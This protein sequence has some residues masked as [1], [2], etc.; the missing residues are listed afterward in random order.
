VRCGAAMLFVLA[1]LLVQLELRSGFFMLTLLN[2]GVLQSQELQRWLEDAA[3]ERLVPSH[4]SGNSTALRV[5]S[6]GLPEM[7]FSQC[8]ADAY[9]RLSEGG[10]KPVVVR[11][12]HS[13]SPILNW[14]V[15][16]L[17]ELFGNESSLALEKRIDPQQPD[18]SYG[19]RLRMY[20]RGEIR[21][22]NQVFFPVK[23]REMRD[24]MFR[25]LGSHI[26]QNCAGH[27]DLL[28]PPIA[29]T[30][31]VYRAYANR[32]NGVAWHAHN[33]EAPSTV[34]VRGRKTWY[35]VAPEYTPL[36][37]PVSSLWGAVLFAQGNPYSYVDWDPIEHLQPMISKI[38]VMKATLEA[39]DV[40]FVPAGWW[41]NTENENAD[42]DVI[43][44]V[45]SHVSAGPTM[46]R[47]HLPFAFLAW[48][49]MAAVAAIEVTQTARWLADEAWSFAK[50]TR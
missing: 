7:H 29:L 17:I 37:R 35:V 38:P 1:A 6:L 30:L 43:S 27:A 32:S 47:T 8:T 5:Q 24:T 41:H 49:N 18:L 21:Q 3:L 26:A 22:V 25:E 42:M 15:D 13:D 2:N 11:G 44:L 4:Y 31:N 48:Y 40:L 12:A 19:E 50:S 33:I 46:M 9:Q 14:T 16:R 39:G 34:H 23:H 10:T 45:F 36:L 20:K 28:V